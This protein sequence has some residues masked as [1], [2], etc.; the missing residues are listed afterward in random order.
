MINSET[1]RATCRFLVMSGARGA[2][3]QRCREPHDV[4]A[5]PASAMFIHP[6]TTVE[7]ATQ[8]HDFLLRPFSSDYSVRNSVHIMH[9]QTH[10]HAYTPRVLEHSFVRSLSLC[11][12]AS[13]ACQ[14][15]WHQTFGYR[16]KSLKEGHSSIRIIGSSVF[17][18][19]LD[20]NR[21]A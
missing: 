8:A 13:H 6:T 4:I 2:S 19:Y 5:S 17:Q 15:S 21:T 20:L 7:G 14:T 3:P 12:P 10:T 16:A 9:A 1:C 11:P 18:D